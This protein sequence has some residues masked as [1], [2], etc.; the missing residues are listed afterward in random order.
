[1]GETSNLNWLYRISEP[2]TVSFRWKGLEVFFVTKRQAI[3]L[4][5]FCLGGKWWYNPSLP[6]TSWEGV[7]GMFLGPVIPLR[8]VLGSLGQMD[9]LVSKNYPKSSRIVWENERGKYYDLG[10]LWDWNLGQSPHGES[11][12]QLSCLSLVGIAAAKREWRHEINQFLELWRGNS[13]CSKL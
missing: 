3:L 12:F 4:R 9:R 13:S 6:N 10:P 5:K 1:M 8:Q 7:L 11:L 2:W